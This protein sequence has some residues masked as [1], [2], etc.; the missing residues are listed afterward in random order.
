MSGIARSFN[1]PP[2]EDGQCDFLIIAGEHS[3]DEQAARMLEKA[4]E[5][6]PDASFCAL[7]G[8]ALKK[9]GAQ[10]LFD[11]TSFS[12]VGLVEVL[13]NYSAFKKLSDEL[14]GWIKKHRPKTVCFVDYPGFN[15]HIAKRLKDE[16]L[17]VKGGGGIVLKYYISPQ[18]WAWKAKRR[19]KMAELLDEL[20]VIFPFEPECYADTSLKTTFVGHPFMGESFKPKMYFDKDGALLF[21]PG[22]RK[23]A[24][25]KIFP[26]MLG[27]L[28]LLD[29]ERAVVPYPSDLILGVLQ[30]ALKKFPDL[31]GRVE[32]RKI[33][34]PARIGA[35]AALMSSGTISLSACLQAIPGAIVYVANPITYFV[36]RMFV[37][38]EYLSIANIILKKP[39]W[40]EFIQFDA[41]PKSIADRIKAC[42]S[43]P[44]V[45]EQTRADSE[46]LRR[47]L[48][49]PSSVSAAEWL[50]RR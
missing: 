30:G 44:R 32:L 12:V 22:S 15:L 24:V 26:R 25:E 9:R 18:I 11:M 4:R 21:M 36:G 2:P 3:G 42:I 20:A 38:V 48:T 19:F 37:K 45:L 35:K 49:A 28:R 50:L 8:R 40:P 5:I 29:G 7:G 43:D 1:F 39:A 47:A 46:A 41:K 13:K 17:S 27:A 6:N 31:E 14:I 16:G 23:A 33:S 10:L 34:D